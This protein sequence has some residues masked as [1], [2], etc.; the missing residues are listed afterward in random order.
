[1]GSAG[2]SRC[3]S[4]RTA[5]PPT[6]SPLRLLQNCSGHCIHFQP[7]YER[8]SAFFVSRGELQPKVLVARL[9]CANHVSLA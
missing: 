6:R 9:D 5:R 4:L 8:I 2:H 7:T 3:C 1:M